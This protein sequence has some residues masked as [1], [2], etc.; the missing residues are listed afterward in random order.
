MTVGVTVDLSQVC[1]W[2]VRPERA[3]YVVRSV[4]HVV[5]DIIITI[6][7]LIAT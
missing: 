5:T 6:I 3:H 2:R 7:M 4:Q 1:A